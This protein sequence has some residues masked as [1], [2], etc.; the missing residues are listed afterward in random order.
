MLRRGKNARFVLV[1]VGCMS[2]CKRK[3]KLF[4]S[5]AEKTT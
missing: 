4:R 5:G 2:E 3:E 1:I